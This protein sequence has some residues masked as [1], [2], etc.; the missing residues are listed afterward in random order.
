MDISSEIYI[1]PL[2]VNFTNTS[3]FLPLFKKFY[4]Q[5]LPPPHP[6]ALCQMLNILYIYTS[7]GKKFLSL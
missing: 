2:L 6:S 3:A 7:G 1:F 5:S 4:K